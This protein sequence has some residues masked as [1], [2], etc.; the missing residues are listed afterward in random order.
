ME[1]R[2]R[3]VNPDDCDVLVA[4]GG[5]ASYCTLCIAISARATIFGMN[6]GTVGFLLDQFRPDGLL[7]R[8]AAATGSTCTH[9]Q[10][11]ATVVM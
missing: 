5:D 10:R 8:I 11:L 9:W 3:W 4:L 1:A 6:R 7:E 2:Y